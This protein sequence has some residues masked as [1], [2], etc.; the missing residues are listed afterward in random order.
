[1]DGPVVLSLSRGPSLTGRVPR[2]LWLGCDARAEFLSMRVT[3]VHNPGAGD[4]GQPAGDEL[5]RLLR[6]AGHDVAYL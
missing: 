4:S 5:Q 1:M 3:L 6:G 2:L